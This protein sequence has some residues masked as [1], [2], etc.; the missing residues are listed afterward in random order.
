MESRFLLHLGV[1]P[2]PS[3]SAQTG[4]PFADRGHT[5][6]SNSVTEERWHRIVVDEAHKMSAYSEDKKTLAFLLGEAGVMP[7][8]AAVE[9]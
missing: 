7:G 1:A 8:P 6:P 4:E 9:R 2:I 5:L 3:D